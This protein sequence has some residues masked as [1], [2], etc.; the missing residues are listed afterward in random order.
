LFGKQKTKENESEY[1]F[2]F[3]KNNKDEN[4]TLLREKAENFNANPTKFQDHGMR[5]FG[6]SYQL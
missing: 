6:T 2:T 1:D 3:D 5:E 4:A